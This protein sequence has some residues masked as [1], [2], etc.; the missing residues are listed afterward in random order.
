MITK[1]D[2]FLA[3]K[4]KARILAERKAEAETKTNQVNEAQQKINEDIKKVLSDL[5]RLVSEGH[6]AADQNVEQLLEL[7]GLG[8]KTYDLNT[9]EASPEVKKSIA[10]R[11]QLVDQFTKGF[12]KV[13]LPAED[14]TKAI[15]AL[16]SFVGADSVPLMNKYNFSYNAADKKLIIDPNG[17]GLFNG[18]PIM[19]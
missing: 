11:K 6:I 3:E 8:K 18:H 4:N 19:G 7:F 17:K 9:F 16:W 2:Q 15:E 1:V 12:T 13:G 10:S 5:N 14:I